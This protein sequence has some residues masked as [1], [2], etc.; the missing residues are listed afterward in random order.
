MNADFESTWSQ[1]LM[2]SKRDSGIS[3]GTELRGI[4]SFQ[5]C[6][7]TV[8]TEQDLNLVALAADRL[9]SVS[10]PAMHLV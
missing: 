5:P 6:D 1:V 9:I 2:Q 4:I 7:C 10:H 3:K 8:S